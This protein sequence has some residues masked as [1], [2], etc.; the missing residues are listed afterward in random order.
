MDCCTCRSLSG[1]R[2]IS[3]GPT[4][5]ERRYWLIEHAYPTRLKGWLVIVLKR[6]VEALHELTRE[7]FVELGE[8]QALAVRLLHKELDSA[9]EYVV[10]FA[11]KEHFQHIHLHIVAIPRDLPDELK[12]T[13]VF[14]LI[15]VPE[16]EALPRDDIKTFCEILKARCNDV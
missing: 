12:G 13:K 4:I 3:P 2:R 8:L 15:N 16:A 11:E 5:C 1:E 10:C 9:K 7:E 6:H 14:A